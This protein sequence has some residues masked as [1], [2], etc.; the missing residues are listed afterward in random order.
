MFSVLNN[1]TDL[2]SENMKAVAGSGLTEGKEE[3]GVVV[4]TLGDGRLY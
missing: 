3:D 1:R 2:V 4:Q